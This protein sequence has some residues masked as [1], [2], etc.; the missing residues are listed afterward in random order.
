MRYKYSSYPANE[1]EICLWQIL[2]KLVEE[3]ENV[4]DHVMTYDW[5]LCFDEFL[6]NK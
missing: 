1:F 4:V 2:D 6:H 5:F 3:V